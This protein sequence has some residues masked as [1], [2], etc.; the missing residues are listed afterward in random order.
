L[1]VLL[2]PPF[3]H[4]HF[5]TNFAWPPLAH[6]HLSLPSDFFQVQSRDLMIVLQLILAPPASMSY[7]QTIFSLSPCFPPPPPLPQLLV[8]HA[9]VRP[10]PQPPSDE[11][12]WQ[13]FFLFYWASS[14]DFPVSETST[15]VRT[16]RLCGFCLSLRTSAF[17]QC[18]PSP[19]CSTS[20][21]G[22]TFLF[23]PSENA[24][25]C[26]RHYFPQ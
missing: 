16:F 9:D 24:F 7:L 8:T 4:V 6:P 5:R 13:I 11:P 1:R 23:F 20:R 10:S 12:S 3:P 25:F 15:K 19:P 18:C 26:S 14:D 17:P 21:C 22:R 2:A